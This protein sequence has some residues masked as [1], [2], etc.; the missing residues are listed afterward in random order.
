MNDRF[1]QPA[2]ALLLLA[3]MAAPAPPSRAA[4]VHVPADVTTIQAGIYAASSGDTVLV[5]CGVYLEHDIEL[6]SGVTVR[7]AGDEADCVVVDGQGLDQV[8][9]GGWGREGMR[10]ERLTITGGD[11]SGVY[12]GHCDD[13][14]ISDCIFRGNE[15]FLQ[16]G[17]LYAGTCTD[18]VVRD[19]VFEDNTAGHRGGGLAA[20]GTTITVTGCT[21]T[22]NSSDYG[23]GLG[24]LDSVGDIAWCA[25]GHNE[26][27]LDG[28]GIIST[29][30]SGDI[31]YCHVAD[32]VST[33]RSGGGIALCDSSIDL[34]YC[35]I[36]RNTAD[37]FGGGLFIYLWNDGFS[38]TDL[39][40]CS[41]RENA[42][43]SGGGVA[44]MYDNDLLA[45]NTDILMN[46]GETGADGVSHGN[47]YLTCCDVD[48]EQWIGNC[49]LDNGD[50]GV[51]AERRN[52]STVRGLFR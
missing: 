29:D 51:P 5:A 9:L 19:C 3:I 46:V 31:S 10:L 41:I 50:C 15:N 45:D 40:A 52:W 13:V 39:E 25:F 27:L 24:L 12:L 26:V 47:A 16:G 37:N 11:R 20:N 48:L 21:F 44:V 36:E 49:H 17:G 43:H 22:A 28:G 1:L 34:A 35:T 30:S 4:T 18:I 32:N 14:V 6:S 42:A 7:G 8:F 38:R 23:G 2:A 33:N